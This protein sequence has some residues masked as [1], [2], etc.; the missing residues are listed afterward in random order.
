MD[1]CDDTIMFKVHH[2]ILKIAS[3]DWRFYVDWTRHYP[4][5]DPDRCLSI[6]S[7][8]VVGNWLWVYPGGV[9]LGVQRWDPI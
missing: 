2:D 6:L 1:T 3:T 7:P 9:H 4:G 5:E 8:R